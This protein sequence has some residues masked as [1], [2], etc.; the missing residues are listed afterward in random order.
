MKY[1]LIIA[2]L[3]FA[4]ASCVAYEPYYSRQNLNWEEKHPPDS[5]KLVHSVFLIGDAGAAN[6]PTDG[7]PEPALNLLSEQLKTKLIPDSEKTVV[8]LGDNIYPIGLPPEDHSGREEAERR[9]ITQMDVVKDH[10]GKVF[11]IPGNHDWQKSGPEGFTWLTRQRQFIEEYIQRDAFKPDFGCPGPEVVEVGPDVILMVV[12]S[13]W[14]LHK[15]NRPYGLDNVCDVAD[16]FDFTVHLSDM[17]DR[18]PNKHIILAMHHPLFSNGNHGG[19]YGIKDHIFPLTLIR[20]NLY[21]P[22]PLIGSIYPLGRMYGVSRQDISNPIYQKMKSAIL[23]VTENRE[24]L[25]IATGHDHTL[26]FHSY[27]EISQI[28]SGSGCKVNFS[29]G[30]LGADYVHS[31]SGFAKIN[32]YNNGE[33]WVEF[34]TVDDELNGV[35]SF[36]KPL[37][38]LSNEKIKENPPPE[39]DYRDSTITIAADPSYESGFLKKIFLGKHY[40]KEW[41]TPVE[42]E[43]LDLSTFKGGLQPIKLGGGKQTIS[44]RM[45]SGNGQQYNI[46]S[47]NKDPSSVLPQGFEDTFAEDLVQDQISTSHPYGAL[48]IPKLSE[49]VNVMHTKPVIRY[50]PFSPILGTY[51][52][53]I[54]GMVALVEI[55]PDENLSEFDNFGNS[56]NVVGTTKMLEQLNEDNDDEVDPYSYLRARLLDMMVGDWDRHEDQWRWAEYDKPDKGERMKAVPRDRDQV[57]TKFDGL[58][59]AIASTRYV[60]RELTNFSDHFSDV[61]GLN[62]PALPLDRRLLSKLDKNEWMSVADSVKRELTDSVIHSA[63]KELPPEIYPISGPELIRKLKGRRAELLEA[64]DDFYSYLAKYVDVVGS[65][66][67]EFVEVQRN[68]DSTIVRMYK[69]KKDGEVKHKIFDR[70]FYPDE[71]KEIRIYTQRGNDSVL[72]MGESRKGIKLRIIGGDGPDVLIDSSKVS[73][74]SKQTKYYDNIDTN[75]RIFVANETRVKLKNTEEVNEYDMDE[76]QF[77][78]T[79]PTFALNYDKDYGLTPGIGIVWLTYGFRKDPYSSEQKIR[80]DFATKLQAFNAMYSGDFPMLFSRKSGLLLNAEY[81]GSSFIL[82]YFGRGNETKY[83]E[84]I[85]IEKFRLRQEKIL[86]TAQYKRKINNLIDITI[87]P[88]YEKIKLVAVDSNNLI[89]EIPK[90]ALN[91]EEH[92]FTSLN[93]GFYLDATQGGINPYRGLQLTSE[94]SF[95]KSIDDKSEAFTNWR[96]EFTF[97]TTPNLPVNLTF[98][99]RFGVNTNFGNF[100]YFLSNT[101]G[102]REEVRGYR[103]TRFAGRTAFFLNTEVRFAI[104]QA[105]NYVFSGNYGLHGFIDNGKISADNQDS[106]LIHTGYGGG[107][108]I[109]LFNMVVLSGDVSF[110]NEGTY[111]NIRMGHFF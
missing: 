2:I 11:F 64:A 77:N 51:M 4:L 69:T 23:A 12:D 84:S 9:I 50:V 31:A 71:T 105:R 96:N 103:R 56:S 37:Y 107:A 91:G 78:Y 21:I 6:D 85:D 70:T 57:Y 43:Y 63:I 68:T 79:G 35:L 62:L 67:H 44:L 92:A 89:P 33:A 53:E 40:R 95:K 3:S 98:A 110:S 34:W 48:T 66:K 28:I 19:H 20:D 26:Q 10:P 97:Y 88:S 46:R 93:A 41:A 94:A 55:R 15:Y 30:G 104:S 100:P 81:Y 45:M 36:R 58:I 16:E 14:W 49:A 74:W 86:F 106:R 22:L 27:K 83:D 75:N 54:G 72:V 52:D 108:W 1:S 87:G 29:R 47:V 38:A 90:Q 17:L 8:F 18:Y 7:K 5:A 59:P 25:V 82:N 65:D 42:L 60:V 32:Y 80:F 24:N 61:K 39:I 101:I 99:L 102:G 76:Y 73:G 13:E 111:Y 109:S